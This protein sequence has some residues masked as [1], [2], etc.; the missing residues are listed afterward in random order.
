MPN[1]S[2]KKSKKLIVAERKARQIRE[3][4]DQ[5]LPFAPVEYLNKRI[6][7]TSYSHKF[8][9][10]SRSVLDNSKFQEIGQYTILEVVDK[11]DAGVVGVI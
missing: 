5:L 1:S 2:G 3:L 11:E 7:N 8:A 10:T 9:E 4:H 6:K